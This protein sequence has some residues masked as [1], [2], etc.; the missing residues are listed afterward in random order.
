MSK[1]TQRNL[2][3][4]T[5]F[6]T[7]LKSPISHIQTNYGAPQDPRAFLKRVKGAILYRGSWLLDLAA[8]RRIATYTL[9]FPRVLL[10]AYM[11][12]PRGS[13]QEGEVLGGLRDLADAGLIESFHLE[14]HSYLTD[15]NQ[16]YFG[17]SISLEDLAKNKTFP[18]TKVYFKTPAQPLHMLLPLLIT[19]WELQDLRSRELLLSR[20]E[21][22]L[23]ARFGGTRATYESMSPKLVEHLKDCPRMMRVYNFGE[24]ADGLLK[25]L[26]EVPVDIVDYA[27][28]SN[29]TYHWVRMLGFGA[30]TCDKA[31][32]EVFEAKAG[33]LASGNDSIS[34]RRIID[35]YIRLPYFPDLSE[36]SVREILKLRTA[37]GKERMGFVREIAALAQ[38]GI[39]EQETMPYSG[40]EW[41][42]FQ[43]AIARE[44]WSRMKHLVPSIPIPMHSTL[45]TAEVFLSGLSLFF[46][47]AG[48][49]G[50][51]SGALSLQKYYR[52]DPIVLFSL[53]AERLA[54]IAKS[55]HY[56]GRWS[57]VGPDGA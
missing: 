38:K 5:S 25:L 13:G 23:R 14:Y 17:P 44:V 56:P 36:V 54:K 4:I 16:V 43:E 28:Y 7:G 22:L 40:K 53:E 45:K 49:P 21:D 10:P 9:F 27:Y 31:E 39:G 26:E 11:A 6:L 20:Q 19:V 8:V 1:E 37:L 52:T 24:E 41:A 35:A 50:F 47:Q 32:T 34:F 51:V 57:W 3:T 29:L 12:I 48:V 42:A 18:R 55:K 46:W 2:E 30:A 15:L 33:K